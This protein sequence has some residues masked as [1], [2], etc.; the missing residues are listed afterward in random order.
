MKRVNLSFLYLITLGLILW[1][2]GEDDYLNESDN[3]NNGG[4]TSNTLK[5]GQIEIK[6]Y[7]NDKNIV[8][9]YAIV[10][11]ITIDWGDGSIDELTPNNNGRQFTHEYTNGN[12]QTIKINTE[13]LKLCDL[14]KSYLSNGIFYEL[15]FGNCPNLEEIHSVSKNLTVLEVNKAESLTTLYCKDNKLTSL[16]LSGCK[17]LTT[18]DCGYNQLTSL[19]LSGCDALTF[20]NCEYNQ[21]IEQVL[22]DLFNNLPIVETG[23]I[24]ISGNPGYDT[25]DR[26]I[27]EKKGWVFNI[28]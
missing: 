14:G 6:V 26:G 4:S 27:A 28:N 19:N 18:L 11:Q 25:C 9:F 2:C 8:S 1:S 13:E 7:P 12:L 3:G 15:R 16:D 10:K 22:N 17:S 20:L 5:T 21:L 23:R 24:V